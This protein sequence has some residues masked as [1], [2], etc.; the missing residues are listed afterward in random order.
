VKDSGNGI[1][2]EQ[3]EDA[4]TATSQSQDTKLAMGHQTLSAQ[5]R[6]APDR[7]L[8]GVEVNISYF[9]TRKSCCRM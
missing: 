1:V 9:T 7:G 2:N 4:S 5:P 8:Q 6:R 3:G